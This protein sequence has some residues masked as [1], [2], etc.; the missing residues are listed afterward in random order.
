MFMTWYQQIEGMMVQLQARRLPSTTV[1]DYVFN[2]QQTN[3][4]NKYNRG[5]QKLISSTSML[6]TGR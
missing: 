5:L 1:Q 2:I 6:V 4:K 3:K